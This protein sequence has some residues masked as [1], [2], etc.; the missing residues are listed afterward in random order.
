[1]GLTVVKFKVLRPASARGTRTLALQSRS[2]VPCCYW[3]KQ[4]QTDV[5]RCRCK[6]TNSSASRGSPPAGDRL[7]SDPNH[8]GRA[9]GFP[10]PIGTY[11]KINLSS[12]MLSYALPSVRLTLVYL[13]YRNLGHTRS[14]RQVFFFTLFLST[15]ELSV[16]LVIPLVSVTMWSVA[17]WNPISNYSGAIIMCKGAVAQESDSPGETALGLVFPLFF[18]F[19][20]LHLDFSFSPLLFMTFFY[21]FPHVPKC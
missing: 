12:W 18:Y 15:T 5:A 3:F 16:T 10:S 17:D 6:L 8:S 20:V 4:M 14:H 11:L 1:M 7:H 19:L 2:L 9:D 21:L 13:N